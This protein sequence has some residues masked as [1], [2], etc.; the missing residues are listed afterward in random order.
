MFLLNVLDFYWCWCTLV[1]SRDLTRHWP[2]YST[3]LWGSWRRIAGGNLGELADWGILRMVGD[4]PPT[5]TQQQWKIR[6]LWV[7]KSDTPGS[8]YCDWVYPNQRSWKQLQQNEQNDLRFGFWRD[9]NFSIAAND[10]IH[11]PILEHSPE[12]CRFIARKPWHSS[13]L[14]HESDSYTLMSPRKVLQLLQV[15]K[16]WASVYPTIAPIRAVA[17]LTKESL[18]FAMGVFKKRNW[19]GWGGLTFG[20]GARHDFTE[21]SE[22]LSISLIFPEVVSL[23]I[24]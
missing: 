6:R 5:G 3:S 2:N 24:R 17:D 1:L 4:V 21:I 15:W 7:K 9:W 8:D 18:G 11:D 19:L 20:I 12:M 22:D 16:L 14:T 13:S 10:L 23:F